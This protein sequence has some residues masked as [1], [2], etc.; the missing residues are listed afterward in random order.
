VGA[1]CVDSNAV[2]APL[3]PHADRSSDIRTARHSS[4]V[5]KIR[6]MLT[7]VL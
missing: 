2:D 3:P 5:R 1:V 7:I 4:A 6:F